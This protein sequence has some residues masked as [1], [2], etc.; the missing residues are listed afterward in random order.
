MRKLHKLIPALAL[1]CA[2]QQTSAHIFL[3]SFD[4]APGNLTEGVNGA[5]VTP[6]TT[7]V[8]PWGPFWAQ[9]GS[10]V[11]CVQVIEPG[12]AGPQTWMSG[13][14]NTAYVANGGAASRVGIGPFVTPTSGSET[15]YYSLS[16]K[17]TETTQLGGPTVA[18]GT[19]VVAFNNLQ[20]AQTGVPGIM[21]ARLVLRRHAT[22]ANKFQ[23][24]IN[25]KLD[26]TSIWEKDAGGADLYRDVNTEYFVVGGYTLKGASDAAASDDEARLWVQPSAATY[27]VDEASRPAETLLTS[28]SADI[29]STAASVNQVR[30]ESLT[31]QQRGGATTP[32]APPSGIQF[33]EVRIGTRWADVAPGAP[34]TWSG[35]SGTNWSDG[36]NWGGGAAAPNASAAV[37]TFN[38]AAGPT[39]VNLNA[40]QTVGTVNFN[41]ANAYTVTAGGG[42]LTLNGSPTIHVS[43][44]NHRISSPV[45]VADNLTVTVATGKSIKLDD[46]TFAAGS[47][48]TKAGYGTMTVNNV[49]AGS[50]RMFGGTLQMAPSGGTAA[51]ASIIDS[52]EMRDWTA[53]AANPI[54]DYTYHYNNPSSIDLTDNKLIIRNA[55]LGTAT[56]GVY[57]GIQGLVQRAYDF[58]AWDQPGLKT[59]M[60][61]AIAGLTTIGVSTGEAMRGLGPTDTDTF[62]GQ[63]ITG[64]SVIAM[65]TYAG[66]AN[67]DGVIDGGDY[68]TIDNFVQ[69]PGA[70]GYANGD[71]NYDGVID[72][73]DYGVIDNNIQAQ[74]PAIPTS[75]SVGI[76]G[77]TAVPEPTCGLAIFAAAA[78]VSLLTRR[79]RNV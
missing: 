18:T 54:P 37:A 8:N 52:L 11:D 22:D 49:R 61:D 60:P 25:K 51:G 29:Y 28:N 48:L 39:S 57:N 74:G 34:A 27:G 71:F 6:Y 40:N 31:L 66:D 17:V 53:A 30:I 7:R 16:L 46:V 68:G 33:D 45:S 15:V 55:T 76:A 73:G 70:S 56:A 69:V 10:S 2:A 43:D 19:T 59:S 24:G 5:P 50:V 14:G 72:G 62:A 65:Y 9:A 47:K 21:A 12:L 3:E 32:Q 20:D 78:G 4:Y 64:A 26:G 13:V 77:V 75:G 35:A 44:G 42:T 58:N 41:S 23:I 67:L 79:R 63:T 38:A 36:A 1:A